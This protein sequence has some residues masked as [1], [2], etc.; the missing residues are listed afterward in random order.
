M[1]QPETGVPPDPVA[2]APTELRLLAGVTVALLVSNH[3]GVEDVGDTGLQRLDVKAPSLVEPAPRTHV[4]QR[5]GEA[6]RHG[7]WIDI[8]R[9]M[10]ESLL[11]G[12]DEAQRQ[13]RL[14]Q[15]VGTNA[16]EPRVVLVYG[17]LDDPQ[18][19]LISFPK[20]NESTTRLATAL[21]SFCQSP[22]M[23]SVRWRDSS[24]I[25]SAR[26][27]RASSIPVKYW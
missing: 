11:G 17:E 23:S 19:S 2:G 16:G 14:V 26:A 10:A 7:A 21:P 22:A 13:H 27:R 12:D 25:P 1:A 5:G 20:L 4:H 18:D 9:L 6:G 3:H 8:T 24:T 15:G